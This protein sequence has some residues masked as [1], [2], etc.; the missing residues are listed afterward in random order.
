MSLF[1]RESDPFRGLRAK[2]DPPASRSF[3]GRRRALASSAPSCR[4][5][6]A[7][8]LFVDLQLGPFFRMAGPR[9]RSRAMIAVRPTPNAIRH[10]HGPREVIS[11]RPATRPCWPALCADRSV[12]LMK[13]FSCARSADARILRWCRILPHRRPDRRHL[14]PR[15]LEETGHGLRLGSRHDPPLA[16]EMNLP[17][18][19]P[20]ASIRT[21][22]RRWRPPARTFP[23][24][25]H[26]PDDPRARSARRSGAHAPKRIGPDAC[27]KCHDAAKRGSNREILVAVP[28][29]VRLP[30][31]E[32]AQYIFDP[33]RGHRR[34]L[35]RPVRWS[36]CPSKP[37]HHRVGS[38]KFTNLRVREEVSVGA[39]PA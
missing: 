33:H 34:L 23:H 15:G 8:D 29:P 2:V 35:R 39:G 12:P 20:T 22:L 36:A 5:P 3:G 24:S 7:I 32:D 27:S 19:P 16:R 21:K 25:A 37:A 17:G 9:F 13:L 31:P 26:G 14:P 6:A 1:E 10:G 18:P 38:A 4:R 28:R 11:D 30:S